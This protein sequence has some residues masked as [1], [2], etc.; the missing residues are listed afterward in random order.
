VDDVYKV[1]LVD[2]PTLSIQLPDGNSLA[3][4]LFE[5]QD[6]VESLERK[7]VESEGSEKDLYAALRDWVREKSDGC[8]ITL[9]QASLLHRAI[10]YNYLDF[11]KKVA[12]RFPLDTGIGSTPEPSAEQTS[13]F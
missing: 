12:T 7:V 9:S 13:D 5:A 10:V 3:V 11:K 8:E 2:N 6:T 1:S 4:D